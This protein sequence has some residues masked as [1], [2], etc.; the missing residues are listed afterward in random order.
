MWERVV[1]F[2]AVGAC[3]WEGEGNGRGE[4]GMAGG[5]ERVDQ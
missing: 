3:R 1:A 5:S 2:M 4:G